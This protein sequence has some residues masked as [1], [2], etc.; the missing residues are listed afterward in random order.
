MTTFLIFIDIL[1]KYSKKDI[2]EGKTPQ[3]IYNICCTLRTTFCTSYGINKHNDLYI[4]IFENNTIIRFEGNNL[5][6]L[7]P[8]E[9]SQALLLKKALD[10]SQKSVDF[11]IKST[12][13]IFVKT[14]REDC[15]F[16]DVLISLK[17]PQIACMYNSSW[18][19]P[20]EIIHL[21][22]KKLAEIEELSNFNEYIVILPIKRE[23]LITFTD[24][25]A[26]IQ[27]TILDKV[28]FVKIN[29]INNLPD[30]ILYIN[31][32]IDRTSEKHDFR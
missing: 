6:Y 16:I 31:Y 13:G 22:K 2:D 12:P 27:S 4:F 5:R 21:D 20:E 30:K 11:W 15:N 1:S 3:D 32:L 28:I 8:D 24:M 19:F 17:K 18:T 10:K 29:R 9:R 26:K 14:Y 7:G 23:L 25:L